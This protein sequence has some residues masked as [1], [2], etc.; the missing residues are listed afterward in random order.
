MRKT[1][2]TT[3]S[4]MNPKCMDN[5]VPC[6]VVDSKEKEYYDMKKIS[7][8][9][10]PA[11]NNLEVF[12]RALSGEKFHTAAPNIMDFMNTMKIYVE[13]GFDVI[14]LSTSNG[15]SSGSLNGA[16]IAAD[17]LNG[18]FGKDRVRIIDTLTAGSGGCVL[19]SYA[20]DLTK[21]M[22][23][24]EEIYNELERVKHDILSTYYISKV[25][26]FVSSGRAPRTLKLSDKLS[27]RYRI[28]V[29]KNGNLV[30]AG[31]Y[32]GNIKKEFM[33][34][35]K[36]IINEKNM[37][38][39]DPMYIEI[40]VTRLKEINAQQIKEYINSLNYFKVKNL[41]VV[42]FYSAISSYGVEDQVGIGL[43]KKK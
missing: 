4:C 35:L 5:M 39:Y 13:N 32:R 36:D 42:P 21:L 27:L 15:I 12:S 34:Y 6:I 8:D 26:G 3:D 10:I 9:K 17:F 11:I 40:L 14:H 38:K 25:E 2:I 1:V 31:I 7:D 37:D 22:V 33:K 23:S 18:D 28:D 24:S 30:P 16:K 20:N 29:N 41:E 19:N 43:I